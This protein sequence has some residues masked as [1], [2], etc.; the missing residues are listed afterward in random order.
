ML[1]K[2]LLDHEGTMVVMGIITNEGIMAEVEV[3]TRTELMKP[4][5]E[6]REGCRKLDALSKL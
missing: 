4:Q 5:C 6:C 2:D 1:M 3:A